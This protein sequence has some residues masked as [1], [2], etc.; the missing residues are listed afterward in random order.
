M[1]RPGARWTNLFDDLES[2]LEHELGAEDIDL[3][4][5]EERLRLGRM[6][7]R[8]R[9]EALHSA[10]PSSPLRIQLDTD[11]FIDV[12]VATIGRDWLAGDIVEDTPRE[13]QCVVALGAVT[14]LL[15]TQQ[16]VSDSLIERSDA[17]GQGFSARLGIAF[18]LRDLC[19]RRR[20]IDLDLVRRTGDTGANSGLHGTIDRVGRDHFDIAIHE[21]GAA[22]R[23][24]AVTH[25]QLVPFDRLVVVRL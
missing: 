8:S 4:V 19:R 21:N 1:E 13:S 6:S 9:L 3:R 12:R 5:E 24:S 22:R 18:V 11:R 7:L 15:L 14:G 23:Q 16:Q 25:Y 20:A 17:D 10:R 2:Q